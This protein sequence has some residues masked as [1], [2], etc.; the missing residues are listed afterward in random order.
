MR[1]VNIIFDAIV[2]ISSVFL[3]VI[4]FSLPK[5][6]GSPGSN[7]A[8]Y[9]QIILLMIIVFSVIDLIKIFV[10][11]NNDVFLQGN[12]KKNVKSVLIIT[13][14]ITLFIV[15]FKKIP[16][17]ILSTVII[18]LQGIVLRQK[19]GTA[20]LIAVVLS[21]SVYSLFVYGLNIIL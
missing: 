5:G 8:I 4:S 7:P 6:T 1:K 19:W 15:L 9:P 13:L 3:F 16:F 10:Q 14:L 18:F 17:I 20:L 21:I 2:L 11:K 12:E